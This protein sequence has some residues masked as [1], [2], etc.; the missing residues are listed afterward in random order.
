MWRNYRVTVTKLR[1][2]SATIQIRADSQDEADQAALAAYEKWACEEGYQALPLGFPPPWNEHESIDRD[3]EI[4][5]RFRCVDCGE[6]KPGEY[7]GVLEDV[8]AASGLGPNDGM[9]CL[10]CLERRIGHLLTEADF[11][12]MPY[13]G[14]WERHIAAREQRSAELQLD[15]WERPSRSAKL[16][17]APGC[18]PEKISPSEKNPPPLLA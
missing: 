10:A 6:D 4:D 18:N 5:T 12:M 14:A 3:P 7:Y 8:W 1:E 2:Y 15:M 13:A 16:Q 17:T 11:A 9:L